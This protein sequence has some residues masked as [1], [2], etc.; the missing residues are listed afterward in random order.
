MYWEP[1]LIMGGVL[2]IISVNLGLAL[3]ALLA[4]RR[5]GAREA[6]LSSALRRLRR[7]ERWAYPA[8]FAL[9]VTLPVLLMWARLLPALL[10]GGLAL[11][12]VT[13]NLLFSQWV[14]KRAK[15][16]ASKAP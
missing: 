11:P 15:E 16:I 12:M 10:I 14:K 4:A 6:S 5:E 8:A 13:F 9:L 1:R 2:L 3:L 7:Q